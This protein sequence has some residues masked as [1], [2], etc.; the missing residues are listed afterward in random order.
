MSLDVGIVAV[1][2]VSSFAIGLVWG[3]VGGKS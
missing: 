2:M 3:Y 1:I